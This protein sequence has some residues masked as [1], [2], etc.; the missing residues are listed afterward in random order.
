VRHRGR[1][2][3]RLL[4]VAAAVAGALPSSDLVIRR[5]LGHTKSLKTKVIAAT[6]TEFFTRPR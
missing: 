1:K 6:L 3:G 4:H 2:P 5:G